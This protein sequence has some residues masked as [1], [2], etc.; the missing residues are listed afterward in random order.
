VSTSLDDTVYTLNHKHRR[1]KKGSLPSSDVDLLEF[2]LNLEYLEAEFFLWG[3][4]GYGLDKVD[5][6]LANGGPAPFGAQKANLD[7]VTRDAMYQFGLQEVGH[8][9]LVCFSVVQVLFPHIYCRLGSL[10]RVGSN[11]VDK[12]KGMGVSRSQPEQTWPCRKT[13]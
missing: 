3:S 6:K 11:G 8:L 13:G 4:V 10:S 2:P 5:A 12:S 7:P 1:S 9:R